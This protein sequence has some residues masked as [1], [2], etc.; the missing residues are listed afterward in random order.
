MIAVRPDLFPR[1]RA[2]ARSTSGQRLCMS[3]NPA[4]TGF[5]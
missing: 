3:D 5:E 2:C 4:E 1:Q